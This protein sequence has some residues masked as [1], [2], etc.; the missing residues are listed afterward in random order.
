MKHDRD[1]KLN[2]CFWN[3]FQ[4]SGFRFQVLQQGFT[5]LEM[6]ISIGIFS[7]LVVASLGVTLGVSNAQIKAANIQSTQDNIRFS[8]EL[9]TKEMRTGSEY[10]LSAF[11]SIPGQEINFITSSGEGR[12][13]YLSDGVIKRVKGSVPF[14]SSDCARGIPLM[15]DEVAVERFRLVTG[16]TGAGSEDGQ[17]RVTISISVRS[18]SLKDPLE[19]RMNLETTVV[20]RLREF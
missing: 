19:S 6:I 7:V 4:V 3:C 20:Q 11:C 2:S 18:K 16:G 14:S 12:L 5:L 1:T 13:Y 15:A 17:S 10:V 9:I 8:L